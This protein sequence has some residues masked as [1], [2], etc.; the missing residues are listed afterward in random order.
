[1]YHFT[2]R[3]VYSPLAAKLPDVRA[4]YIDFSRFSAALEGG[5]AG[6]RAAHFNRYAADPDVASLRQIPEKAWDPNNP[7]AGAVHGITWITL[8]DLHPSLDS[9]KPFAA[10]VVR[11]ET[12]FVSVALSATV[13]H[14]VRDDGSEDNGYTWL[15]LSLLNHYRKSEAVRW[16][17]DLQRASRTDVGWAQI[18][19]RCR[20]YDI[21]MTF[22]GRAYDLGDKGD[23]T[24]LGILTVVAANDDHDRREK[25]T[26]KRVAKFDL[27]GAAVPEHGMP[28]GWQH[29]KDEYGRPIKEGERGFIPEAD[30]AMIPVLQTLYARHAAGSSYQ[31]LHQLLVGFEAD[32]L[33]QR[34][35][36]RNP[37]NTYAAAKTPSSRDDAVRPFFTIRG[38]KPAVAPPAQAIARYLDGEDP[39]ELFEP[40]V[41]VYLSRVELIRTGR[42]YR[43]LLNDM[44]GIASH[45]VN[46]YKPTMRDE[47]DCK[48]AFYVHSEP[49][50]WPVDDSGQQV[51]SFGIDDATCRK[52][53]A[54]LLRELSHA[55]EAAGGRPRNDGL[56][57]A[58][59]TFAPWRTMPEDPASVYDDEPTAWGVR[60]RVQRSGKNTLCVMYRPASEDAGGWGYLPNAGSGSLAELTASL[61]L[62]TDTAAHNA[63]DSI[64]VLT[65]SAVRG[66]GEDPTI[67]WADRV[68]RRQAEQTDLKKE[69]NGFNRLAA[70]AEADDDPG[71][72]DEFFA[73]AR[74]AE[75][76][77]TVL[78]AEI[79]ELEK[80]IE[81]HARAGTD[82]DAEADLTVLAFLVASLEKA[83]ERHGLVA[84]RVG[85]LCDQTFT[86]WRFVPGGEHLH[87]SCTARIP[88]T[89]GHTVVLPLSGA[90]RNLHTATGRKKRQLQGAARYV[91]AE[92]RDVDEVADFV[93]CNRRTL[94]LRYLMPWLRDSGVEATGLKCA[95]VDHPV[96]LVRQ[97]VWKLATGESGLD[98]HVAPAYIARLQD[99]Y[100]DPTGRWGNTAVPDDTT[101]IQRAMDIL[102]T[103]DA[104]RQ[105]G[106]KVSE[107]ALLLGISQWNV[108]QLVVPRVRATGFQRPRFLEYADAEKTRVRPI[109]CPHDGRAADHVCLLPEVA[110]SGVGVLCR[111]CRRVPVDNALWATTLF[112][113]VYVSDSFS[114]NPERASIMDV[115][116]TI[117]ARTR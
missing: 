64:D 38:T 114:K 55:R 17:D 62:A 57:R 10:V 97:A 29:A 45:G 76:R 66:Q 5:V 13:A 2:Q 26:G 9:Q 81:E 60:A 56:R 22:G 102:T 63:V 41:R 95:L 30:A 86:D 89:S 83:S 7:G 51:P 15:I 58:L 25:L 4:R 71:K 48:G 65:L 20:S 88:V 84:E 103:D 90:I 92:G 68:S 79:G 80:L 72:R 37:G 94:Y 113:E 107:L 16:A 42:Y 115:C 99:T 87:W 69:V 35:D 11:G 14:I 105:A 96:H 36:H 43:R 104:S 8:A 34:R 85:K 3:K 78:T 67:A 61:A 6:Q 39:A 32:G 31:D 50:E 111:H 21:K 101:V 12:V 46:G 106:K 59:Q 28:K 117:Q 108:R 47:L 53:G 52:V 40:D 70:R 74:R 1:M 93:G 82:H 23:R 54:R 33:L 44:E 77:I 18:K 109:T 27:G 24:S 112:P 100:F 110:A 116:G 75:E 91:F 19:T 49:W 73:H 98:L